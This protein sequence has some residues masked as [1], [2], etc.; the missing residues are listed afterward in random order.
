MVIEKNDVSKKSG[1]IATLLCFFF[2]WTGAHRFYIGKWKS[3]LIFL[4]FGCSIPVALVQ[5]MLL[6]YGIRLP[7]HISFIVRIIG[8]IISYA[9]IFF[10][11]FAIYSGTFSD[12]DGKI[13][14]SG[15]IK[16]EAIGRSRKEKQMDK[17]NLLLMLMYIFLIYGIY[18]VFL[19]VV[20]I[21]LN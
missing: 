5:L 18:I 17:Y 12:K 3:A 10:D 16:D 9:M 4:L 1:T 11:I 20:P 15:K 8:F 21:L 7:I 13:L 14:L 6:S 19:T 2:G